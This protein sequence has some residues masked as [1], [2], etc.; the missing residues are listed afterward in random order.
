MALAGPLLVVGGGIGGMAAAIA[1]TRVGCE[2]EIVELDPQ[3][4]ALGAGLTLNGGALRALSQLGMMENVLTAGYS[5]TGPV[6]AFD[7]HGTVVSEGPTDPIFDAGIPNM[8][9]ILRPKFHQ[10]MREAVIASGIPVR[11]G[12]SI[13]RLEERADHVQVTTNDG[14]EAPY[15][16]VIGADGLYSTTRSLIFPEATKPRFTGQGCWRAVVPRPKDVTATIVYFG[17]TAKVGFNPISEEE[18]YVYLLESQPGNPWIPQSEW[19]DQMRKKLEPFHG[20]LGEIRDGLGAHSQINYRPLEVIMLP[21]PWYAGHVLL[22]GDA[23]HATTPHVGYGAGLA[24]EDAVV[25]GEL[26][27]S[28]ADT[29]AILDQFMQRRYER[30]RTILQGSVEMG[31]MEIN[32]AP[33]ADQRALSAKLNAVIR[34]DI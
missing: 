26:V 29:P 6:R 24:I 5:S 10:V 34:Q 27:A 8:G 12:V 21:S 7:S 16:L 19:V 30:C 2:V 15:A 31:D 28:G 23:A 33:I 32:H 1:L 22:I 13:N 18:M 25:L 9:G 20:H 3:W 4:R 11:A 14:R 17:E